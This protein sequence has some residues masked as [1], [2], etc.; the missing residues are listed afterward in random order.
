VI[1]QRLVRRTGKCCPQHTRPHNF[2]S[3]PSSSAVTN[4]RG[5]EGSD[6]SGGAV[7]MGGCDRGGAANFKEIAQQIAGVCPIARVRVADSSP[8]RPAVRHR[9]IRILW[10]SVA[11]KNLDVKLDSRLAA[12][13]GRDRQRAGV[14]TGLRNKQRVRASCATRKAADRRVHDSGVVMLGS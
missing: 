14:P 4:W 8:A 12:D 6:L 1:V 9:D 5:A 2:C 3:I 10:E 7:D 13:V 11:H